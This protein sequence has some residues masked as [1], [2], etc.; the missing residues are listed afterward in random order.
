MRRRLWLALMGMVVWTGVWPALASAQYYNTFGRNKVQYS[1]FDWQVMQTEHIDL[2]YYPEERALAEIAAAS[3]EQSYRVLESR[4]SL[5]IHRRI[6]LILYSAHQYFEETNTIP[7]FLPESVGAFTEFLKGRVVIPHLGSYYEFDKVLRH[8]LVHVFTIEK[9]KSV[10]MTHHRPLTVGP[11]LWFMEGLAE[12]WSEG[13]S[14]E[15][16]MIIR[17]A[18]LSGY[19]VGLPQ[20]N[21]IYGTFLMYKEGE[22]FLK[23]LAERYGDEVIELMFE[24]WWRGRSFEEIVRISTGKSLNALS[25][26]WTYDLRKQYYPLLAR[27]DLPDR[28]ARPL[29]TRGLN[30]KPAC[31]PAAADS[32]EDAGLVFLS[33]REGYEDLCWAPLNETEQHVQLLVRGGRSPKFESFHFLRSKMA[34]NRNW[35]VAFVSQS[36]A[37]DVLYV[38]NLKTRALERRFRF[39]DLVGLSSP[40]WSPDGRRIVFSGL[41]QGGQS[42]LYLVDSDSGRLMKLTNDLYED[43]DPAW[44]PDGR[45]LAFTSDRADGGDQAG[46]TNLFMIDPD[47]GQV[48]GLTQGRHNDTAPAW[49]PD[50]R[51]LAFTSDRDTGIDVYLMDAARR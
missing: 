30:I 45:W 7:E 5:S 11:P 48:E 27:T 26:E 33:T 28:A 21:A 29:T 13:W 1:S 6:P 37:Q 40:S 2:Y 31:V 4:F 35:Q 43:R 12:H 47:T 41:S 24:N 19:L 9:I 46:W 51:W 38:W 23:F 22:S 10:Y 49:S 42:D 3:A 15:A 14:A 25:E 16:D 8:E 36:E 34:V 44:S 18:V 50:G 20:I 39:D 32:T 17:D